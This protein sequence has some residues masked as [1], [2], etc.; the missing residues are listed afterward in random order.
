MVHGAAM[1][2]SS[3]G[4]FYDLGSVWGLD[5]STDV[6]DSFHLRSAAGLSIFWNTPI[7]PLRFDFSQALQKESYDLEQTFDM[8]LATT[9]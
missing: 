3:A 1:S 6:D 5:N 9:F 2:G 4:F 8:S 7:G